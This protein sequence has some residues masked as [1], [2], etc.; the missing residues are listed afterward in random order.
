MKF[1][2]IITIALAEVLFT[3]VSIADITWKLT[4]I[5]KE[6]VETMVT[7]QTIFIKNNQF[8]IETDDGMRMILNANNN[9][10]TIINNNEKTFNTTS[11][12]EIEE[13]VTDMKR[14]T[15]KMIEE[16]LKNIPESQRSQYEEM[17]RQQM[18]NIGKRE[19]TEPRWEKFKPTGKTTKIA[20]YNAIQ[21]VSKEVDG[22]TYE[23]WC[24]NEV[25]ISEVKGFFENIRK[26]SFFKEMSKNYSVL[27]LGFPLKTINIIGNYEY[28]SEVISINYDNISPS[29]FELPEGYIK[30]ES[31]FQ[32]K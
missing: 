16:A 10:F 22:T 15:D 26:I 9:T 24:S 11:L 5:A 19:V 18:G 6:S 3:R 2:L 17:L 12:L 7:I 28:S 27:D 13:K 25:E 32:D 21:Y 29:V 8:A 20:G 4:D 1:K 23:M 31:I 30:T 14:E